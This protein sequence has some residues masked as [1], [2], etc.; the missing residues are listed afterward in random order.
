[1]AWRYYWLAVARHFPRVFSNH[2]SR[3]IETAD[4]EYMAPHPGFPFAVIALREV[5]GL[6]W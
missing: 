5:S 1:M 3:A 2:I 6:S 4:G